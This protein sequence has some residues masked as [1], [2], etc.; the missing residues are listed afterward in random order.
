MRKKVKCLDCCYCVRY[1][2]PSKE[3]LMIHPDTVDI[4]INNI[5]CSYTSKQ[6]NTDNEQYCKHY[7]KAVDGQKYG[8][9]QEYYNKEIKH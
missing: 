8:N 2:I 5:I 9:S 1:H 7:Q 3:Y 4:L 6:K